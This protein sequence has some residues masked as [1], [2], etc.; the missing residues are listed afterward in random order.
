MAEAKERGV[1][2]EMGA[3][4][5]HGLDQWGYND[6]T[7]GDVVE[8]ALADVGSTWLE[9]GRVKELQ[10]AAK[11]RNLRGQKLCLAVA[12][13]QDILHDHASMS[14][15]QT[16]AP[17]FLNSFFHG[18]PPEETL[19]CWLAQRIDKKSKTFVFPK[20]NSERF[21]RKQMEKESPQRKQME[22]ES[23]H[24]VGQV[25]RHRSRSPTGVWM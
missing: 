2:V 18:N 11:D 7:A 16:L 9:P 8:S 19:R 22:K 4:W 15:T 13:A 12:A 21:L 20:L 24:D 10:G 23:P 6:E 3:L 14:K 25:D 5:Q 17:E 1:V